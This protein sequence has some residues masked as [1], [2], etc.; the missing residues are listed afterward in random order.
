MSEVLNNAGL[1]SGLTDGVNRRWRRVVR[2]T[3]R[4]AAAIGELVA[5]GDQR[6]ML[7]QEITRL[8][9]HSDQV[10]GCWAA[11]MLNADAYAKPVRGRPGTWRMATFEQQQWIVDLMERRVVPS[12]RVERVQAVIDGRDPCPPTLIEWLRTLPWREKLVHRGR[13]DRPPDG[14]AGRVH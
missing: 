3:T 12:E 11:V 14:R 9:C 4:L 6:R 7:H 1:L 10:L 13:A 5:D 2:D 8:V